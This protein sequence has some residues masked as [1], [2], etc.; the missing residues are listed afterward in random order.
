MAM[1]AM[2]HSW[3]EA[4]RDSN[5]ARMSIAFGCLTMSAMHPAWALQPQKHFVIAVH[6][7]CNGQQ[8]GGNGPPIFRYY[9]ESA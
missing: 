9:V 5:E 7:E 3:H 8:R 1:F 6:H 2:R 4:A